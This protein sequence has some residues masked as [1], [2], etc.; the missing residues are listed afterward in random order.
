MSNHD[1]E[2]RS[3]FLSVAGAC[4]RK[5]L[6]REA[7]LLAE[8]RLARDSGDMSA[9][10]IQAICLI[11]RGRVSEADKVLGSVENMVSQW[12][13]LYHLL[14]ET[15]R[16]RNLTPEAARACRKA[17]ILKSVVADPGRMPIERKDYSAYESEQESAGE[18][19]KISSDFHT[20][21]LA[22][23]YV[24]QG[25]LE[26]AR[27]VLK[28]ITVREPDNVGARERLGYVETVLSGKKKRSDTAIITE[29]RRWMKNLDSRMS[30]RG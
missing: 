12:S 21:T 18:L 14:G 9:V 28:S 25:H 26:T 15:Y 7:E 24:K 2:E 5:E 30:S 23:L 27:A 1:F 6:Y 29:L 20:L 22:D 19:G 13:R 8:K 16:K 10:F 11:G 3:Q 17:L 4:I